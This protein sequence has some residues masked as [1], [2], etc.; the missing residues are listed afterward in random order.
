MRGGEAAAGGDT[1]RPADHPPEVWYWSAL[2][3]LRRGL[4][5]MC[6]R[7]GHLLASG[8]GLAEVSHTL[9]NALAVVSGMVCDGAKSSCAAKIAMA[10]DAGLLGYHMFEAGQEFKGG[11]GI[12]TKGV[13]ATVGNVGRLAKEGMRET[14]KEIIRIMVGE[15]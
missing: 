13:D 2:G 12:V 11:D 14:D 3:F 9:V 15:S 5:W 6:R 4:R 1:V 8:G 10:V 7:G